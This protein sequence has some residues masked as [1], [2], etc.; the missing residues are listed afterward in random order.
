MIISIDIDGVLINDDS[1]R[2]DR[3]TKKLFENNMPLMDM[4]YAYERKCSWMDMAES[5]EF[6]D[7]IY[8]EYIK[9][10]PMIRYADE[11]CR[12]IHE[13]GDILLFVTGRHYG[14]REDEKGEYVRKYTEEW[15]KEHAIYYDELIFSGFP[16]V[17]TFRKT[18]SDLIIEDMPQT[19]EQCSRFCHVFCYDNPYNRDFVCENMTRVFSW[20]DLYAKL[21]L[22]RKEKS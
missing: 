10:A 19:L 20:Y 17:E 1:Y 4:P 16:K 12:K 15:M 11:V 2:R 7:P 21:Q 3:I 14:N 22:F 13:D 18:G 6:Y 8:F 5:N 9:E